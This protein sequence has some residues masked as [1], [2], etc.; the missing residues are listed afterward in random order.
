M[1]LLV[2]VVSEDEAESAVS[3]GAHIIDVKNPLEGAL[4]A[5]FPR[6]IRGVRSRTPSHLP[7]SVAIGDAP[8]KP[9]AA[10]LAALGAAVCNVQYVKVGLHGTATSNDAFILLREVRRAVKSH[11]PN[12]KVIAAA[13]ADARHIG[14]LPPAAAPDVALQAGADG[15]MLDTALK[16]GGSIFSHLDDEGLGNF[17]RDCRDRNLISALAGSLSESDIPRIAAI[18]PDIA[19][20]RTAACDGDRVNG[21]VT[22]G[23]VEQLRLLLAQPAL[24]SNVPLPRM[25][26]AHP[27]RPTG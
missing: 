15:C 4:G 16:Q 24:G 22:S 6:V 1:Q 5:N 17:V 10:A 25:Q 8:N 23:R 3:G 9:G 11:D 20:F 21:S 18:G 27:C 7:V 14:S 26:H 13:Y 19:G 2:S 12:I